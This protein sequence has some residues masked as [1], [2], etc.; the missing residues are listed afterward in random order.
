[1]SAVYKPLSILYFV[2]EAQAD[3]DSYRLRS[4]KSHGF[5]HE[6]KKLET[7]LV[8]VFSRNLVFNLSS[9]PEAISYCDWKCLSSPCSLSLYSCS[10]FIF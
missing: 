1:M 3:Q 5:G 6:K 8:D 2:M 9:I 10:D 7:G 4:E